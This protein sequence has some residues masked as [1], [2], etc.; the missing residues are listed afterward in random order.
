M[1][2]ISLVG[3]TGTCDRGIE[4][5]IV[6]DTDD[7]VFEKYMKVSNTLGKYLNINTFNS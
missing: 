6:N 3:I 1:K 7:N 4:I 5:L 2:V